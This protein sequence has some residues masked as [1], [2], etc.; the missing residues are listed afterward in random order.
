MN[1]AVVS[2]RGEHNVIFS[3]THEVVFRTDDAALAGE[4]LTTLDIAARLGR[5]DASPSGYP[6]KPH[7]RFS[8]VDD[9]LIVAA[10]GSYDAWAL[11]QAKR[12]TLE[13]VLAACRRV[14]T[15]AI[16]DHTTEASKLGQDRGGHSPPVG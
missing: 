3:D 8:V 6:T 13:R 15:R 1:L 14:Y 5:F 4:M 9:F 12:P 10:C 7:P 11:I 2:V 16:T